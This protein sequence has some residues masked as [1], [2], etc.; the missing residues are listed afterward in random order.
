MVRGSMVP[1]VTTSRRRVGVAAAMLPPAPR[2]SGSVI[3]GVGG[4]HR[5]PAVSGVM[6]L[7]LLLL[8]EAACRE[9]GFGREGETA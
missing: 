6:L 8:D 2:L 7:L 5:A 3:Q 1:A 9:L 4:H